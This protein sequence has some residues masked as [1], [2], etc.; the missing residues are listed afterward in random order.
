MNRNYLLAAIGII[1]LIIGLMFVIKFRRINPLTSGKTSLETPAAGQSGTLAEPIKGKPQ[2]KI[3]TSKGDIVLEL[4]PDLA[5]LTV[6]NF[7][8]KWSRGECDNLTFHRVEDWVVQGCDPT[9]NGTGGNTTLP[10]EISSGQFTAGAVGVARKQSP[11]EFSNDS[12]FFITKIDSPALNGEYTYFG[13]VMSGMDVV[14][15]LSMGDKIISTLIL[16]K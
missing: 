1:V 16:S 7:L 15:S 9:G 2:V 10:T 11:K 6:A 4:R 8:G 14:S 13:Q 5:P 12:Q 3:T